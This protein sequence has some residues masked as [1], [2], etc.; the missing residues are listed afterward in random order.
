MSTNSLKLVEP[1]VDPLARVLDRLAMESRQPWQGNRR[2][3]RE[4]VQAPATLGV[5]PDHVPLE[6]E[7]AVLVDSFK[8]LHP[9]WVTD[10]SLQGL[11][12]L[13]EHDVPTRVRMW[14]DLESLVGEPL[15]M[16]IRVIYCWPLLAHTHRVGG[17]FMNSPS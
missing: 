9:A 6:A 7:T 16:P 13:V 14:V 5:M 3:H 2:E 8:P 11:G 1:C 10:L 17:V 4:A 15:V 12:L